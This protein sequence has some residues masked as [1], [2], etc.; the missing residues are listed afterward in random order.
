MSQAE[1]SRRWRER[2]ANNPE[3]F[4]R[5]RAKYRRKNPARH[6][7]LRCRKRAKQL[8]IKFTITEADIVIPRKCPVLG[9]SLVVLTSGKRGGRWQDFSPTLDRVI[10]SR[11]YVPGNV[12][13]ISGRANRIKNDGTL[14]EFKRLVRA[15]ELRR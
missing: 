4:R 15:L 2:K 11:G 10:P 1:R 5:L 12:W 3:H 9:L 7:F 8:G 6:M 13:V 14:R